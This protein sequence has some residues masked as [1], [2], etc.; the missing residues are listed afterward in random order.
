MSGISCLGPRHN[1]ESNSGLTPSSVA[2]FQTNDPDNQNPVLTDSEI[3]ADYFVKVYTDLFGLERIPYPNAQSTKQRII[4]IEAIEK[5]IESRFDVTLSHIP[6]DHIINRVPTAVKDLNEIMGNIDVARRTNKCFAEEVSASGLQNANSPEIPRRTVGF[7]LPKFPEKSV[8]GNSLCRRLLRESFALISPPTTPCEKPAVEIVRN[9]SPKSAT[10]S[11][12]TAVA[13]RSVVSE[14][15][16][17]GPSIDTISFLSEKIREAKTQAVVLCGL[18][19]KGFRR[20]W[21]PDLYELR[22]CLIKLGEGIEATV[23]AIDTLSPNPLDL[24]DPDETTATSIPTDSD[25]VAELYKL[26]TECERT[27]AE[28]SKDLFQNNIDKLLPTLEYLPDLEKNFIPLVDSATVPAQDR[29]SVI[30]HV[31]VGDL[32]FAAGGWASLDLLLP[33]RSNIRSRKV[34]VSQ[35]KYATSVTP[36]PSVILI[37]SVVLVSS[38]GDFYLDC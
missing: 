14:L 13:T 30:R 16:S 20:H 15:G 4:N 17:L 10:D 25:E 29:E 3:D 21:R 26:N 12:V 19:K 33:R 8:V 34:P 38:R 36:L 22:N 9:P 31:D 7:N 11:G 5:D 35:H 6:P 18:C 1:P 23:A 37:S 28:K 24:P 27:L 32:P 2:A